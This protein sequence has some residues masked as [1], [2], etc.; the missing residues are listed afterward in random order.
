MANARTGETALCPWRHAPRVNAHDHLI[1]GRVQVLSGGRNNDAVDR[2]P[3]G[4]S[5]VAL[6][7]D[8]RTVAATQTGADGSFMLLVRKA[9]KMKSSVAHKRQRLQQVE[10]RILKDGDAPCGQV[11]VTRTSSMQLGNDDE[12]T[13]W[14]QDIL[15]HPHEVF[16]SCKDTELDASTRQVLLRDEQARVPVVRGLGACIHLLQS[17]VDNPNSFPFDE[18]S[19][20]FRLVLVSTIFMALFAFATWRRRRPA[21]ETQRVGDRKDEFVSVPRSEQTPDVNSSQDAHHVSR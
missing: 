4:F 21:A 2:W 18:A 7:V 6:V 3:L 10:I 15:I 17:L 8:A 16:T 12:A 14:E 11:N 19:R 9:K 1:V 20:G 5:D 13:I